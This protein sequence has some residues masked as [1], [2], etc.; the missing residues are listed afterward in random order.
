MA[1]PCNGI[2]LA[3]NGNKLLIYTTTLVN[4]KINML[5]ERSQALKKIKK[6]ILYDFRDRNQM[7]GYLW[8]TVKDSKD[9]KGK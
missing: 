2:H 6:Y 9:Y 7:N 4:P 8:I 1:Y 3:V 5:N